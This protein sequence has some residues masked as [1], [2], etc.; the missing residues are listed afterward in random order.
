MSYVAATRLHLPVN[1]GVIAKEPGDPV[2][3]EE[4]QA[5][6]Q[7][8]ENIAQLVEDVALVTPEQWAEMNKVE[9]DGDE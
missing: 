8:E 1:G 5:A 2:S 9:E 4:L 6:K 7:G 3:D